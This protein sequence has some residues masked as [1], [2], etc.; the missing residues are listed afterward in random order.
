M[1]QYRGGAFIGISKR[2]RVSTPSGS[3]V[4]ASSFEIEGSR[5]ADEMDRKGP[6]DEE[7]VGEDDEDDDEEDN[8]D[9]VEEG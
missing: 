3:G 5:E 2:I 4:A 8:E 1:R 6:D 9:D 7:E